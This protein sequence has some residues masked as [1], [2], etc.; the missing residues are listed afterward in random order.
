M[1]ERHIIQVAVDPACGFKRPRYTSKR[2][3]PGLDDRFL[4]AKAAVVRPS[5]RS[6]TVHQS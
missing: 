6:K 4:L 2:V 3:W 1:P 5:R